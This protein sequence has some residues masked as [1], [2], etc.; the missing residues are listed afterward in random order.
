MIKYETI[1]PRENTRAL[2][3]DYKTRESLL[4]KLIVRCEKPHGFYV[5]RTPNDFY[6]HMMSLNE[7]DRVF[8]E[9]IFG[10]MRQ[11]IKF[12][13]DYKGDENDDEQVLS[14]LH[15]IIDVIIDT[16]YTHY[17]ID[18]GDNINVYTSSGYE[19]DKF[20]RS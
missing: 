17:N 18:I 4:G 10:S 1:N 11:K 2:L 12:D 6:K 19:N 15:D 16:F 3:D 13:I 14:H 8:H 9:V 5:F 7:S 20:N